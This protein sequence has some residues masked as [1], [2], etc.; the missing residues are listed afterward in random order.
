VL[1]AS[2]RG[3]YGCAGVACTLT[4]FISHSRSEWSEVGECFDCMSSRPYLLAA[5]WAAVG[6]RDQMPR[7]RLRRKVTLR[8]GCVSSGRI[9]GLG[10]KGNVQHEDGNGECS[11]GL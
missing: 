11:F 7:R 4:R 6:M 1:K 3:V 5:R 9:L 8:G 10:D 2:V